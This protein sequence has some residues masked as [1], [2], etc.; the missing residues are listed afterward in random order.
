MAAG[1]E[2]AGGWLHQDSP[3]LHRGVFTG[4]EALHE[5]KWK[6]FPGTERD[7]PSEEVSKIKHLKI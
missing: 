4:S 3:E 1:E 2:V 7:K 5:G 6:E